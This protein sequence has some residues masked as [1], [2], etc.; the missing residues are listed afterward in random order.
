MAQRWKLGS[1]I[2]E[3]NPHLDTRGMRAMEDMV[4]TANGTVS[5]PNLFFDENIQFAINLYDKPTYV[6]STATKTSTNNLYLSITEKISTNELFALRTGGYV[7]KINKTNGSVS[8]SFQL[9]SLTGTPVAMAYLDTKI[10]FHYLSGGSTSYLYITG[11]SGTQISKYT[12]NDADFAKVTSLTWDTGSYVYALCKYGKVFRT[13]IADG[14]TTMVYSAPD[15]ATNQSLNLAVYQ[16]IHY[17]NDG[18]I[19]IV[20]GNTISYFDSSFNKIFSTD[21]PLS[22]LL[23]AVLDYS[24]GTLSGDSYVMT[25]TKIVKMFP[26]KCGLDIIKIKNLISMGAVTLV[27]DKGTSFVLIPTNMG[28][29]RLRNKQDARY[30]IEISGSLG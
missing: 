30:E 14:T 23:T 5:N 22:S 27:D 4:T 16:G 25:Q 18:I 29:R 15:Y 2:V 21:I 20:I 12:I 7:D 13:T 10:A 11:E 1:Y 17:C 8:S 24:Y 3:Y 19:G 28:I 6:D 9:S 26:N